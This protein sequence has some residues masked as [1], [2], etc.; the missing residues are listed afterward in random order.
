MYKT[1]VIVLTAVFSIFLSGCKTVP[2]ATGVEWPMPSPPVKR[3]VNSVPIYE[4]TTFTPNVDGIFLDSI[5][6]SNLMLNIDELDAYI[7]KQEALI[8]QMKRY[9]KAK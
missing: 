1:L 3:K 2:P 9:Y 4:G 6:A 8:K 5:S 7:E